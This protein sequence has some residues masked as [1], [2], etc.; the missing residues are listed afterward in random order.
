MLVHSCLY[1]QL[2]DNIID[3]YTFDVWAKELVELQEKY[4]EE[5]KQARYYADF[6]DFDGSSG[7]DLPYSLPN[8][9]A[10]AYKLLHYRGKMY[11]DRY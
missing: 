11:E 3:D 4:P 10:T 8:I 7:F 9:Q 6:K 2:G 5:S 1:Y